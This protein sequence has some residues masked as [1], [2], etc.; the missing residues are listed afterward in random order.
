MKR[1]AL[2]FFMALACALMLAGCGGSFLNST[3]REAY[4]LVNPGV[5]QRIRL[6][7]GGL[8]GSPV[9]LSAVSGIR[10]IAYRNNTGLLYGMGDDKK[11]YKINPST[12]LCTAVNT[13][14]LAIADGDGAMA[15][16]PDGS[17]FYYVATTHETYEINPSLG[18][19]TTTGTNVGY[20]VGDVNSGGAIGG[21]AYGND[22]KLYIS[23]GTND[24]LSKLDTPLG[25][26]EHT[27]G[28][29]GVDV[30]GSSGIGVDPVTGKLYLSFE[31]GP[32]MGLFEV[33]KATGVATQ[34]GGNGLASMGIAVI[35]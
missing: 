11:L 8:V 7:T 14:A 24:C 12:G 15:S 34:I 28:P 35:P 17:K 3:V 27:V 4:L 31:F 13:N 29:Y 19:L 1:F 18:I 33:N 25:G 30:A 22:G 10:S 16:S 32:P 5:I 20:A 9:A 2:G 26:V 21:L 6:D 23:D